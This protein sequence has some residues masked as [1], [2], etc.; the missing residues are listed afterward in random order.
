[1]TG[2]VDLHRQKTNELVAK[3]CVFDWVQAREIIQDKF[4]FLYLR[5]SDQAKRSP[6]AAANLCFCV[7]DSLV[8]TTVVGFF[9]ALFLSFSMLAYLSD[10]D[11]AHATNNLIRSPF[12]ASM[13]ASVFSKSMPSVFKKINQTRN[14]V[15]LHP[16][17]YR[18]HCL[19]V[20]VFSSKWSPLHEFVRNVCFLRVA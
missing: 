11:C 20:T 8:G 6:V 19:E 4:Y 16:T 15:C 10:K 7:D 2:D 3:R 1:M 9:S 14:S 18:V 17:K 12:D 13:N 5:R